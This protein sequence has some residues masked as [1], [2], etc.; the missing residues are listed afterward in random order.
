MFLPGTALFLGYSIDEL[1]ERANGELIQIVR[2]KKI[3][4]KCQKVSRSSSPIDIQRVEQALLRV[5]IDEGT[6][7]SPGMK[8]KDIS[9]DFSI[10][11]YFDNLRCYHNEIKKLA[12]RETSKFVSTAQLDV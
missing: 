4:N 10:V 5:R 12:M 11:K 7:S 6:S 3:L 9:E 2:R 1:I 8:Q